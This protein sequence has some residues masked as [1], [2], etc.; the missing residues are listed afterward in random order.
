MYLPAAVVPAACFGRG[1]VHDGPARCAHEPGDDLVVGH[2]DHLDVV[3]R[4]EGAHRGL[5]GVGGQAV[6]H[7]VE[8]QRQMTLEHLPR[9]VRVEHRGHDA[10]EVVGAEPQQIEVSGRHDARDLAVELADHVVI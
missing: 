3:D 2:H 8:H 7:A 6:D 9:S 5:A 1:P 4:G 10:Y